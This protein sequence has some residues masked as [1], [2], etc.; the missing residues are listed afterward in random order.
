MTDTETPIVDADLVVVGGGPAGM[1]CALAAAERFR[2]SQIPQSS[3]R[4]GETRIVLF[5]KNDRPGKKL[6]VAGSGR[7]NL[8]HAGPIADFFDRYGE[9]GR[10][11][12]PALL[13]FTNDDLTRFFADRGLPLIEL[14][15]GKMF[16]KTESS[17]DVLRILLDALHE[18]GVDFRCNATIE[19]IERDD[20]DMF[21]LRVSNQRRPETSAQFRTRRVVIATGGKTWSA[22][23]STGDGY[24]L[25]RSLG[26][27]IV[28]PAA[29][30]AP[31]R[32][33]DYSFAE[34]AGLSFENVVVRLF[35]GGKK[36]AAGEGD[37]LLTHH[38]LSGPV[39]LD[40]SRTIRTGDEI[41]V[42][43]VSGFADANAFERRLQDDATAFGRK[44]V[45]TLLA[46]YG[47]P[48]RL[49]SLLFAQN[50]I[51]H[52]LPAA[53]LT[54]EIRK[55]LARLLVELPFSVERLGGDNEAMVTRGGVSL[56]E[57]NRNTMQ[58]RL[59]PNLFFCGETLDVDGDSGGY[60][61]Q[62]A[63]SSGKLAAD[64]MR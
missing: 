29:A 34:C 54:R 33:R 47:V 59:V 39:I 2:E 4:K 60:N 28:E 50:G 24:R 13:H 45:K 7:C 55:T 31:V 41:R 37:L 35:R 14:N 51:P 57:I 61:L 43:L 30:L 63:F 27:T 58:S 36:I 56:A 5:E 9:H 49:V 6:L 48:E 26:H 25:A 38:G 64:F 53:E 20:D 17:R 22:T 10:F 62:F 32:V 16:P 1:M 42:S 3:K 12:R 21:L 40:M 44:H 19:S 18:S 52:D 8:T 46:R 15:D 11:V 23:G